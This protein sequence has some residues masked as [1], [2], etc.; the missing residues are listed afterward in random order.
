LASTTCAKPFSKRDP[1]VMRRPKVNQNLRPETRQSGSLIA[2]ALTGWIHL[3]LPE[4]AIMM[5]AIL[6]NQALG[7]HEQT[8]KMVLSQISGVA[9]PG[10]KREVAYSAS[11]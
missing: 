9:E 5:L 4:H 1:Q 8:R 6:C 3:D 10:S 2:T 7:S 11:E